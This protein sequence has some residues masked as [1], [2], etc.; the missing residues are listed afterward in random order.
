MPSDWGQET[1]EASSVKENTPKGKNRVQAIRAKEFSA[2][3]TWNAEGGMQ[4]DEEVF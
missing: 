1:Q 3:W 4:Y 2:E